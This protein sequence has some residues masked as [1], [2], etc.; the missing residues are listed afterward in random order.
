MSPLTELRALHGR[1]VDTC[2]LMPAQAGAL[3]HALRDGPG[4]GTDIRQVG[5][6]LQHALDPA[7]YV[8]AWY[9][10][11]ERHAALRTRLR[12]EGLE[13]PRQEVLEAVELPV[14]RV[15]WRGI[16]A[17]DIR[18][19]L[20]EVAAR[21][22]ALGF[23]LAQAPLMRLFVARVGESAWSVLWTTH[24][25]ALDASSAA[26]VLRETFEVYESLRQHEEVRL[27]PVRTL[28]SA[29]E[30]LAAADERA[31]ERYWRTLLEGWRGPTPLAI[32]LSDAAGARR[33]PGGRFGARQCVLPHALGTALAARAQA[34]S[35]PLAAVLR[36]AWALLLWRYG[37]GRDLVFGVTTSLRHRLP[38]DGRVLVGPC[39][40]TLPMR[41]AID[42]LQ[43]IDDWLATVAMQQIAMQ[44]HDHLPLG[45]IVNASEA[46]PLQPLFETLVDVD[47]AS[48]A[49]RLRALGPLWRDRHVDVVG[50]SGCALA[51]VAHA[52]PQL[53]LR[54]EYDRCRFSDGVVERM[55]GH[56][57][58]VLGA[59]AEDRCERVGELPVLT[60]AEREA[61]LEPPQRRFEPGP[62]LHRAFE[63]HVLRA[64]RAPALTV[65]GIGPARAEWTYAQLDAQANRLARRLRQSGVGPNEPVAL[66][67]VHGPDAVVG[68]LAIL[69]SGGACL[70]LPETW[71]RRRA[72]SVLEDAGVRQVVVSAPLRAAWAGIDVELV[73]IDCA[74]ALAAA[75]ERELEPL[76]GPHDLAYVLYTAGPDA[77]PVGVQWTHRNVS[78]LL[79]SLRE[80]LAFDDRDVWTLGPPAGVDRAVLETWGALLH[81]ARLVVVPRQV[82]DDGAQLRELLVE[83]RVT[84]LNTTPTS[85][86]RLV[87]AACEGEVA[88][89][90]LRHV[91]IGGEPLDL[92]RLRPWFERYG[93]AR[94]Q[95]VDTFGVVEATG[96]VTLRPLRHTDLDEALGTV[97]GEPLADVAL[98]LLDAQGEPVPVGVPGEL[99][100]TGDAVAAGYLRRPQLA[101]RRFVPDPF[102]A[103][104]GARMVLT[105]DR[106]RWLDSGE[107]ELLGRRD[108]QLRIQGLRVEPT[109]IE[110]C[111]ARHPLVRQC[112]VVLR[113]DT[114]GGRRL[115]AFVAPGLLDRGVAVADPPG[116]AARLLEHLRESLPPQM[117]PSQV[118]FVDELPRTSDGHLDE[119]RLALQA[120]AD[121]SLAAWPPTQAVPVEAPPPRLPMPGPAPSPQQEPSPAA[122]APAPQPASIPLAVDSAAD[123][124]PRL[125]P[126][127]QWF[128]GQR[129]DEPD[130]DSQAFCLELSVELSPHQ[131][132]AGWQQLLER[133][134]AL[135]SRFRRGPDGQHRVEPAG[136]APLPP[137][138]DIDLSHASPAQV[139]DAIAERSAEARAGLS[140]ERGPLARALHFRLGPGRADRLLVV[141]HRLAA[142]D[143]SWPILR[144]DLESLLLAAACGTE[145]ALE[146]PGASLADWVDAL[147]RWARSPAAREAAPGWLTLARHPAWQ[148]PQPLPRHR[149]RGAVPTLVRLPEAET[150][151]LLDALPTHFGTCVEAVLLSALARALRDRTGLSAL[152]IDM[153]VDGRDAIDEPLDFSRTVGCFTAAFPFVMTVPDAPPGQEGVAALL[154]LQRQLQSLPG[155]AAGYGALRWM[156]EDESWRAHLAGAPGVPLLFRWRGSRDAVVAGSSIFALAREPL[157]AGAQPHA[158]AGHPL[159]VVAS[160]DD[161]C[162]EV[163]WALDASAV[164]ICWVED[165][166]QGFREAMLGLLQ[167]LPAQ[168][169]SPLPEPT[170]PLPHA[171][172]PRLEEAPSE[173]ARAELP[174]DATVPAAPPPPQAAAPI[175][176]PLAEEAYPLTPA[177]AQ[178][179]AL[180]APFPQGGLQCWQFRLEGLLNPIRMRR[181]LSRVLERHAVLR[182]AFSADGQGRP[183][184]RPV[185]VFDSAWQDEDWRG[186]SDAEQQRRLRQL[187][188]QAARW[189]VDLARPP[190]LRVDLIR[191]DESV[192]HLAWTVHR[193]VLDGTSWPRVLAEWSRT[194]DALEAGRAPAEPPALSF[195]SHVGWLARRAGPDTAFWLAQLS[196]LHG[197]T[198]VAAGPAAGAAAGSLALARPQAAGA[199][200]VPEGTAGAAIAPPSGSLP[201]ERVTPLDPVLSAAVD[202]LVK[203][204]RLDVSTPFV[205][206]W[207]CV[208]GHAADASRVLFGLGLSV[209]SP[210][211]PG[212]QS[213]VGPCGTA[214]PRA[215]SLDG[216]MPVSDWLAQLE[217]QRADLEPHLYTPASRILEDLPAPWHGGL[218]DSL[219]VCRDRQ[220]EPD[221]ARMGRNVTC[222]PLAT[223][224]AGPCALTLTATPGPHP[225]LHW[226]A[227]AATVSAEALELFAEECLVVLRALASPVDGPLAD[228]LALLSPSTRGRTAPQPAAAG[229]AA[230][231]FDAGSMLEAIE[232]FRLPAR[233]GGTP[234]EPVPAPAP[235]AVPEARPEAVRTG[236]PEPSS[237][238]APVS[239]PEPMAMPGLQPEPEPQSFPA[240]GHATPPP[241]PVIPATL[242]LGTTSAVP[243]GC[244]APPAATPAAERAA[245]ESELA[246]LWQELLGV[247]QVPP[248]CSVFELGADERALV[249]M[250]DVIVQRWGL[251]LPVATLLQH[252]TVRSLAGRIAQGGAGGQPALADVALQRARL[253]QQDLRRR[254]PPRG[255]PP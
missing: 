14:T 68:A 6:A 233:G 108:R 57:R 112:A 104:P 254:S 171:A 164:D 228:V 115:V 97:I 177:Q 131:L 236:V 95:L 181:A 202:D 200:E 56:L 218:F 7:L 117:V 158:G 81:G 250:Q 183:L 101:A 217:R 232:S 159:Q 84:V 137:L 41:V 182:S 230:P 9:L 173:D 116:V 168:A 106:A 157:A 79:A 30:Q 238:P 211:G 149:D 37:G 70:P 176:V 113:E 242:D 151:Q 2:A 150:R 91:I 86:Q 141:V 221:A 46:E 179:Y 93:D 140:L 74:Q 229:Q 128:L 43:P 125:T 58:T 20:L 118:L 100:V 167:A 65:P 69:K 16:R 192:W 78:R 63:A 251:R 153:E 64:P 21:D 204:L 237:E 243:Q 45:R 139:A 80:S 4:L 186:C 244:P 34:A 102:A 109:E 142:D 32:E 60:D 214:V 189:P 12:W 121:V 199:G 147:G 188:A 234:S 195:R 174:D 39:G 222:R 166:V 191:L 123:A 87:A 5:L 226:H 54:I 15:D 134:P 252:P 50:Q 55:L 11:I 194:Y 90:T 98:V 76:A 94:P 212:L 172:V 1:V 205:A 215:V 51:L 154:A 88:P 223:A 231:G 220:A 143:R 89:F 22:R 249:A 155:P 44:P 216:A 138:V 124:A 119:R 110:A 184:Q 25:A 111:L 36:A 240:A 163:G 40:A 73:D 253:L 178:C 27:P 255:G 10:V 107:L 235:L 175:A 47:E 197:P 198:P 156:A 61:L 225:A 120:Q 165:L 246:A 103:G 28:R 130:H 42:P 67:A 24:E 72:A 208:L 241:V 99:A 190:L 85:L 224:E 245:C 180:D 49:Q 13:E 227:A 210:G 170:G 105:G 8:Y 77:Q 35:I 92:R 82:A 207:A 193:L 3:E 152:R 196:G 248:D 17:E 75:D 161:G 59:L 148:L 96:P 219:L 52:D 62:P 162:L 136:P 129:F 146:P 209:P 38:D 71:P 114:A 29:V 66:A 33:P 83:E 122:P 132:Q 23:D 135:R 247:A 126:Y 144:E 169:G 53:L 185:D 213:W 19:R 31:A 127:Q 133:H 160:V 239:V 145:P 187:L 206:A 203:R 48:M 18:S 26:R 201:V